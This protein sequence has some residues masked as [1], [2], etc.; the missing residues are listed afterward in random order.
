MPAA[1]SK[2]VF[3]TN[4]RD[5]RTHNTGTKAALRMRTVG[6]RVCGT[7]SAGFGGNKVLDF[8]IVRRQSGGGVSVFNYKPLF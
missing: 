8:V 2:C 7:Y 4:R 5:S 3:N 6:L 1:K